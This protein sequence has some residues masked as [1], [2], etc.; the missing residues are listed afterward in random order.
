MYKA[1]GRHT[2]AQ[3][4][5]DLNL[6]QYRVE[7]KLKDGRHVLIRAVRPNDKQLLQE[8]MHHLSPQSMYFRFFTHKESLTEEELA[9]FTEVDFVHHVGLA[10]LVI[11]NGKEEPAGVARYIT[12][13]RSTLAKTAEFAVVVDERYQGIGVASALF[14]HLSRIALLAGIVEFT[15]TVVPEN[16]KMLDLLANSGLPVRH[17]LNEGGVYE[18]TVSLN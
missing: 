5:S 7:D 13:N 6:A 18:V 15:G 14:K 12:S 2:Q 8:G 16:Q 4:L 9:Y 1:D 17:R 3:A 11:E 10:A